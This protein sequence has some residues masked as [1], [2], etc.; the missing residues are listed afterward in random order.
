MEGPV[1]EL[2]LRP[3]LWP[4]DGQ[5]HEEGQTELFCRAGP[6]FSMA[7]VTRGAVYVTTCEVGGT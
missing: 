5:A 3:G 2:L 7:R 1:R 4:Q 6:C